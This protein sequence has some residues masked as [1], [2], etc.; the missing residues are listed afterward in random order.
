MGPSGAGE[1]RA[2]L[3]GSVLVHQGRERRKMGKGMEGKWEKLLSGA[4]R[5]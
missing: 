5:Q 1:C 2:S 4:R 3:G